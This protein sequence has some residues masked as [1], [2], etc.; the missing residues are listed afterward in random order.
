MT[1]ILAG[2]VLYN[3]EIGRLQ[4]NV[5]AIAPQVERLVLVDN[6]STN[7]EEVCHTFHIE[8]D[9][10][11]LGSTDLVL[12]RNEKNL[13][14]ATALNEILQYALDHDYDWALTLDQDTIPASNMIAAYRKVASANQHL[15]VI[16]CKFRDRHY[17]TED[18]SFTCDRY[19]YSCI[20]SASMV[21]VK[22]W[23][24][25]GGFDDSMFIDMVDHDFCH[26]LW[27]AGWGTYKTIETEILQEVGSSMHK[28][29]FL[30][31]GAVSYNHSPFRYYYRCRNRVYEARRNHNILVG[32]SYA[33][34]RSLL[35]YLV[36]RYEKQKF[37]KSVKII[38]GAWDGLTCP[39][40][41]LEPRVKNKLTTLIGG[42]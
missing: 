8:D 39:I 5:A 2:I 15:G 25:I 4:E 30:G 40:A 34:D 17:V 31:M 27:K 19:V 42:V 11:K 24:E 20:T 18:E 6:G 7:L 26:R 36:C 32:L 10:G 1:K 23:Q 41:K 37:A 29:K 16:C 3:P 14:I 9:R 35:I 28:A 21:C 38:K 33:L 22:A 13:G 12:I